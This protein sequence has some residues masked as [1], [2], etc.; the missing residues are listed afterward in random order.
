[1]LQKVEV[2][3]SDFVTSFLVVA[4]FYAERC[5]DNPSLPLS[6]HLGGPPAVNGSTTNGEIP[7]DDPVLTR[8]EAAKLLKV[9]PSTLDRMRKDGDL[10][11]IKHLLPMVRYRTS[12]VRTY[13]Q[14]RR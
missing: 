10:P 12:D 13:I 9:S 6:S 2:S 14:K 4:R 7:D 11:P 1:M 3:R 5:Y 8:K